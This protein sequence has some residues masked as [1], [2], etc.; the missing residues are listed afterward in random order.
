MDAAVDVFEESLDKMATTD[1]EAN[2]EKSEAVAVHQAYFPSSLFLYSWVFLTGG[3]VCSHLLTLVLHS[4]DFST[5]IMEEIHSSRMSVH[6]RSTYIASQK[7]A[8]FSHCCQNLK[9]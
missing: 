8:F 1:L 6:I 2:R 9:S 5:L 7:T 3:S 4:A